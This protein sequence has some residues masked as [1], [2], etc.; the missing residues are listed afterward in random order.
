MSLSANIKVSEIFK[1][2][3]YLL[4]LEGENQF[5]IRA[6]QHASHLI[7]GLE[8]DISE[9]SDD[10]ILSLKG[11][12]KGMLAH[13][14]DIIKKGSFDEYD[15]L[16]KKYPQTIFELFDI[17][18][19]GGKRIKI[20]YSKLA[21]DTKDK[22]YKAAK[23]G[24][25]SKLEGFGEKI[26][27]SIIEAIEKGFTQQKRFLISEAT[28]AAKDI[29][30]YIKGFGYEKVEYAGSLRRGKETIGDVD[31]VVVGGEELVE[32]IVKYPGIDKVIAKGPTKVSFILK[33]MLE[34]DVRIVADESFG[35][36]LCYFTGSKEH[37]IA[38][39][40]IALKKGLIL[41]EYGLFKKGSKKPIAGKTE[42]EIYKALGMQYIPPELRE[43]Q[44]E[45]ELALK[46]TLPRLVEEADIKGD[47]HCH[48]DMTDG[49][50]SIDEIVEYLSQRYSWFFIADHSSPLNFVKGLD[51][52]RYAK[53]REYLLSLRRK[54]PNTSFDRSIELEILKDGS[55][56]FTEDE[57]R[58]VALVIASVHT[59]TRMKRDEMTK[60]MIKAMTSPWCDVVAHLS[61][62]LIF[63]RDEIDMDYDAIFESAV[64]FNT[65]FEINGQPDRLDLNEV[66]AKK[67]RSLGLKVVLTSDAHTPEQFS[68]I[69]YALKI[70]RR[71]GLTKS[72]VLNTYSFKE[73]VEYFAENRKRRG[74]E[75]TSG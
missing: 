9:L 52:Q 28:N 31:I 24:E 75:D 8:K 33:N 49:A 30:R 62:R 46:G 2:M 34:C 7:A 42:N 36:A 67:V 66:R 63:Q 35:S 56:A 39:R 12:G 60:R 70:A 5:K 21:I 50:L 53:S 40:E 64:K 59:S 22:L 11:I 41:N 29:V 18:G 58:G 43:N 27:Q 48:S 57:L 1:R 71:A 45:I 51:Y 61:G 4:E 20:L 72:D 44:G 68:Y 19:L 73:L 26:E 16:L 32:K 14:R 38:L 55:L 6:Y 69:N 13:I 23:N 10:E 47:I 25:I 37:N 54:Y 17:P 65:V 15:M 3:A 74:Y